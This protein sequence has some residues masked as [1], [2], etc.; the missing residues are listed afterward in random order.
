MGIVRLK[1]KLDLGLNFI[2]RMLSLFWGWGSP[3]GKLRAQRRAQMIIDG[4]GLKS[5][6]NVLEIGCGT[7]MFT[8][9]FAAVV[10][11]KIL[12]V[13]ISPDL[14]IKARA[15]SLL[16]NQVEF[17]EKRFEDIR[18]QKTF[19]VIIGS[20]ILH[21]LDMNKSLEII[22]SLLKPGGKISFAE[23]NM[24]NPQ[25]FLERNLRFLKVF[26]YVS[27]DETAFVRWKLQS[28]L[29]DRGFVDI[30]IK[31]FDW[32]HPAVF[33]KFILSCK[34]IGQIFE[35]TPLIREF[36]G[37]LYIYARLP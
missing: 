5:G 9:M 32:L 25:V 28:L 31:P 6:M 7:G 20:S 34:K 14:I 16:Q 17:L 1:M 19:D 3:A 10:G 30:D 18:L 37:S 15:R 27:P 24:L 2:R 22:K 35:K 4:A 23:P 21:H 29:S 13:D 36:S 11:T 26:S 12:A 8:E 33:P